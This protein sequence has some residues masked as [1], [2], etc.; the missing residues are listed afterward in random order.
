M[1]IYNKYYDKQDLKN[2]FQPKIFQEKDK[3]F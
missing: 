2:S 1:N 3:D